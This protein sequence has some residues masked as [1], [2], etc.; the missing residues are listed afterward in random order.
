MNESEIIKAYFNKD[1]DK[2]LIQQAI[3]D[4]EKEGYKIV[5]KI[6]EEIAIGIITGKLV[7]MSDMYK[8]NISIERIAKITDMNIEK[9]KKIIDL[10]FKN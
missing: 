10:L 5:E 4:T 9:V 1:D 2:S 3:N 8:H 6:S 7:I